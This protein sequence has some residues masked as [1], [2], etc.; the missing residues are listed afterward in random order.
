MIGAFVLY[1]LKATVCLVVFS[2]FFRLLLMKET[3]FRF[4]RI[5]MIAGLVLCSLLPLVKVELKEAGIFQR[6]IT[7][8]ESM[9]TSYEIAKEST[10][11]KSTETIN[12][13]EK[14]DWVGVGEVIVPMAYD[15]V[16]KGI[17]EQELAVSSGESPLV[18][19]RRPFPFLEIGL[20]IYLCGLLLMCVRLAISLRRLW[21]LLR[22]YQATECDGYQLIVCDE[23][24]VPFSFFGYIV[25]SRTDYQSNGREI[26]L[27]EQMH[28]KYRHNWDILFAELFLQIHWFNPAVWSLYNDLRE[29]HEYEADNAVIEEG[30]DIR[31]YQLLLVKKAVG[32]RRFTS[33]VNSFNQSKIKNR[34]GMMLRKE[35][36]SWARLKVL[37]IVPLAAV[38]LLAFAQP[39]DME[40]RRG[41]LPSIEEA[42]DYLTS[43]R[44]KNGGN[45]MAYIYLDRDANLFLMDG[46]SEDGS[47]AVYDLEEMMSGLTEKFTGLITETIRGT[48]H[49]GVHFVMAAEGDTRMENITIVKNALRE[50]YNKSVTTVSR[51]KNIPLNELKDMSTLS[52]RYI[53][54]PTGNG[55]AVVKEVQENPFFY[56]EQV[57][58]FCV[59]KGIQPEDLKIKPGSNETKRLFVI[60]V[61]SRN[62]VMCQN[63][64]STEAF[65][66]SE[67]INSGS[68][69]HA[70]KKM[71]IESMDINGTDAVYFCMQQDEAA[72]TRFV[73]TFLTS[74]LPAAYEAALSDISKRDDIPEE[75]LRKEKPLLLSYDVPR[76]YGDVIST[77]H[78]KERKEN[79]FVIRTSAMKEGEENESL[80]TITRFHEGE[81]ISTVAVRKEV[82]STDESG[83]KTVEELAVVASKLEPSDIALV[84]AGTDMEISDMNGVKG[85]LD[86]RFKV[87]KSIFV[88]RP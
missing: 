7:Q 77:V 6:P 15:E 25:L 24:I 70:L 39:G 51:E 63:G 41:G 87:K 54:P 85:I 16:L 19:E 75:Q 86:K 44:A 52:I 3:F 60:L 64:I 65:K 59:E 18:K 38:L 5:T 8:L 21:L 29:V 45:N 40:S 47:V 76:T 48:T 49:K 68:S 71:I 46:K 23:D 84:S 34:I 30:I 56:W 42:S 88:L 55:E 66:N 9:L 2:L 4:T 72:S 74:T 61:N 33:V 43:L 26:I 35:S 27:H 14:A 83:N 10:F 57:Q 32:E 73:F 81:G 78:R 58:Q 82:L 22:N 17:N 28:I 53:L 62:Q 50:A 20:G 69:I 67:E 37:L 1:L 36:N 79:T 31:Q 80:Y 12:R 11:E 13:N